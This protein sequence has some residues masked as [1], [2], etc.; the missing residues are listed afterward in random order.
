V[1]TAWADASESEYLRKD[2]KAAANLYGAIVKDAT[3]VHV[4]A[5]ALQAQARCLVQAGEKA[6]AIR[7]I[8]EAFSAGRYD[9]AADPQGRLISANAELMALELNADRASSAF[10]S[11]ARRLQQRLIDYA[12]PVLAAPQRRFLMKELQ[13]LSPQTTFSTLAAEELAAQFCAQHPTPERNIVLEST[14]LAYVWRFA[15]PDRR[16]LALLRAD[17]LLAGLQATAAA[18]S[19]PP[20]VEITLLPPGAEKGESFVSLPA[21]PSWP[22]WR[23]AFLFKNQNVFEATTNHRAATYLW[24]GLLVMGAMGLLTLLAVRLLRRQAALARLK[25]DLVATVSHE[26]KTP[27][28]SMRVLVD[29]LLDSERLNEQTVREYLQLIAQE[30]ER[31]S[32][33]IQNFLTFSRMERKKYNFELRRLSARQVVDSAVQAVRERFAAPGCRFEVAIQDDL[34]DIMGDADALGAALVNLLDNAYKYSEELRHILLRASAC[35]GHVIFSIQDNGIGIAPGETKKIFN[36]FHQVDQRLSRKGSGCGL[37]LS[38]VQSIVSV[39][40]GH[41]SVESQPG[42][43]STFT[44][45]L[46]ATGDVRMRKEVIA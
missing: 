1:E 22:G 45:S 39:H 36:P 40:G 38:I 12:N 11:I 24:A 13:T 7:L 2:F 10:Q 32:R 9:R 25:N 34:P 28:S 5:S 15:T 35:N 21:G 6:A 23:L 18:E 37:G 43:G 8:D 27:V 33:L 3:N 16:A 19:L 26:L 14:R 29:T 42:R 41:V 46:P 31:L 20:D 4:A 30:N 44:I 17:K